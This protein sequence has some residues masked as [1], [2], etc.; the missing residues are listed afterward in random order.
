MRRMGMTM[1]VVVCLLGVAW[2]GFT[3]GTGG[4]DAGAEKSTGETPRR[5][6]VTYPGATE[7]LI[8]LNLDDRIAATLAPY[9]IE[10]P[11]LA[12]RYEAI[13]FLSAPYVPS[14][15]EVVDLQPDLI[16]GWSHHFEPSGLGDARQWSARGID[17]Y[18]VPATIRKGRPT[19]E[20]TV[21]SFIDDMGRILGAEDAAASYRRGLESRV[22]AVTDEAEKSENKPTVMILQSHGASRYSLYGPVYIVDDIVRK[23]GGVNVTER[24][25][26]VVGPERVLGFDPDYIVAV[27]N[28]VDSDFDAAM[29]KAVAVIAEDEN[30]KNMSA[31]R[32]GRIIPVPF[33]EVNNGN[34]R[35][36]DGLE[37]IANGLRK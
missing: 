8:A 24:Q 3:G 7:L 31:V 20:E 27:S 16:I 25:L 18:V 6:I 11:E 12:I 35:V 13:P 4:N 14:R 2:L 37:R 5:I 34:G 28:V 10:P 22:K 17:T 21:Y 15:E 32:N 26:S 1:L 9:G 33:A 29:K 30:L 36:V 23:A 19:L